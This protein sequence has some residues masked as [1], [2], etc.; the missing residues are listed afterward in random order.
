MTL[1]LFLKT[2]KLHLSPSS[3]KIADLGLEIMS[4][5]RDPLHSVDHVY[6]MLDDLDLMI[7]HLTEINWAKV[8]LEI[9]TLSVIWHDTYKSTQIF[10]SKRKLFFDHVLADGL[11]SMR[12][13]KSKAKNSGMDRKIVSKVGYA[14]RKHSIFQI[15][16]RLTVES[17]ILKYLD[18]LEDWSFE[19]FDHALSHSNSIKEIVFR[20]RP[21]LKFYFSHWMNRKNGNRKYPVWVKTEYKRR[22]ALFLDQMG[23]KVNQVLSFRHIKEA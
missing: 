12:F 3:K 11:G 21:V 20:L 1:D 17:K 15:M 8:N 14:I 6:R 23:E 2:H 18:E 5:S 4:Q 7:Y 10:S 19:R 16:P 13:F 9:L 22:K